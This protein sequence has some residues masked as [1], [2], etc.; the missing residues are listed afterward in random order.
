[1]TQTFSDARKCLRCGW[2]WIR[3]DR[4]KEPEVCPRCR[5]EKWNEPKETYPRKVTVFG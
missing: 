4:S 1:M 5:T 3:R 2:E